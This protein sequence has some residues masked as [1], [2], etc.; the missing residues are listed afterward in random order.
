MRLHDRLLEMKFFFLS[1]VQIDSIAAADKMSVQSDVVRL[2]RDIGLHFTELSSKE[3]NEFN[4][5][6]FERREG[7]FLRDVRRTVDGILKNA[8]KVAP[9]PIEYQKHRTSESEIDRTLLASTIGSRPAFTRD[10]LASLRGFEKYL[11]DTVFD[12]NTSDARRGKTSTEAVDKELLAMKIEVYRGKVREFE[13]KNAEI[14][15]KMKTKLENVT[16]TNTSLQVVGPVPLGRA[17]EATPDTLI[18]VFDEFFN[19]RLL[20]LTEGVTI[21]LS[22][23]LASN[24]T[25][26]GVSYVGTVSG[27]TRKGSQSVSSGVSDVAGSRSPMTLDEYRATYERFLDNVEFRKLYGYCLAAANTRLREIETA[28]KEPDDG[29]DELSAALDDLL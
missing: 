29:T 26:D 5:T 28:K 1:I 3:I 22:I 13:P 11:Q 7:I 9:V 2:A 12:Q 4:I 17:M 19:G 16:A 23:N 27:V 24:V 15:F 21:D 8:T 20:Y 25:S 6:D 18:V 10:A 14:L